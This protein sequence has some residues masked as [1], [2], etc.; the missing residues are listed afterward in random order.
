MKLMLWETQLTV[1]N[2][3]HFSCLKNVISTTSNVDMSR[4][5]VKI[6]GL[7]QQFET[8]FEIFRELEKEFTVF[9]SPFTAN[10]THLAANLQLKIID[11]KCDSDLKNKF[12]MVGLDTFYKYLLPKYP[13]L[14]ALAAKILS[15][16]GSTYL[17]EQLFSLMNIN[18]TKFRSRLTH[19]YLSEILRLTVSEI[20]K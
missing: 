20:H 2:T 16:F 12:T 15:M 1:G 13:N 4:Y 11:L 5:K 19:T 3:E 6:T 10:I 17:C 14:T 8:R 9:R 7:L 18:K